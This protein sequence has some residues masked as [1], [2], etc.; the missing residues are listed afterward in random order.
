[1]G[2]RRTGPWADLGLP[3][4]VKASQC[5]YLSGPLCMWVC[6]VCW[7]N[8]TQDPCGSYS[9]SQERPPKYPRYCCHLSGVHIFLYSVC[10]SLVHMK[11]REGLALLKKPGNPFVGPHCELSC[12]LRT[13]QGQVQQPIGIIRELSGGHLLKQDPSSLYF[14]YLFTYIYFLE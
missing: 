5:L 11:M 1:M 13:A 7:S 3:C 12:K 8:K 14:I 4:C 9:E 10:S 2:I 6:L